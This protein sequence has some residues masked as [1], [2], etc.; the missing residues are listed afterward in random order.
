MSEL[1]RD[2]AI[3][4]YGPLQCSCEYVAA[5]QDYGGR[6]WNRNPSKMPAIRAKTA[7]SFM[8][9]PSDNNEKYVD[10]R[11]HRSLVMTLQY[12]TLV[13]PHCKFHVS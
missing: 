10:V 13:R 4:A 12:I 8:Q 7:A 6:F 2:G 11:R 1:H 5:H 3:S 9:A